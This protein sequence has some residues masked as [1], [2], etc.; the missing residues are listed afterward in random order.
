MTLEELEER[1]RKLEETIDK[2]N[3]TPNEYYFNID[4]LIVN[5][6]ILENLIFQLDKLDIKEL[7]GTLNLGN[8]FGVETKDEKKIKDKLKKM[9]RHEEKIKEGKSKKQDKGSSGGKSRKKAKAED[10]SS[11]S[12]DTKKKHN[13]DTG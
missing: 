3:K 1:I 6:P 12:E 8:N 4:K 11:S 9:E 5:D 13:I 2:M 7:G 10:A